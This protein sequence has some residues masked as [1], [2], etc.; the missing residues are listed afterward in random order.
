SVGTNCSSMHYCRRNVLRERRNSGKSVQRL[1]EEDV[2]LRRGIVVA[3]RGCA[4]P[5]DIHFTWIACSDPRTD[6]ALCVRSVADP[7][8]N[9]PICA[10]VFR[11]GERYVVAVG[12]HNVE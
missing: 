8:W 4:P 6:S 10:L 11:T 9:C 2:P 12:E 7:N 5:G 3:G 1:R